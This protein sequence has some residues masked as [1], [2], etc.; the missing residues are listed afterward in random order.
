MI[1]IGSA[2]AAVAALL[3]PGGADDPRGLRRF[4]FRTLLF[5]T[6]PAW[7]VMLAGGVWIYDE[8]FGGK[9]NP[10]W[11]HVGV[12]TAEGG[13]VLLLIALVCARVAAVRSKPMLARAAG[14]LGAVA[15][16]S[17]VVAVWAMAAKP[18]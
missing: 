13:L 6:L 18:S 3:T 8:E 12:I 1:L 2:I 15:V 7:I 17:W 11:V 9:D 4:A 5:V 10:T 16:L 14:V